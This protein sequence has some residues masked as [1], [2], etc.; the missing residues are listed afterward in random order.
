METNPESTNQ[1]IPFE[2]N[3][4][5]FPSFGNIGAPYMAILSLPGPT[6]GLPVW[7]L[8]TSLVQNR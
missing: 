3:P 4:C 2:G 7:L 6:I 5:S 1:G 8:S